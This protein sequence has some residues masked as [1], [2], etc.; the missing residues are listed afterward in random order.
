MTERP[1]LFS[2]AMVRSI[3]QGQKQQ[4]RR[5]VKGDVNG[6]EGVVVRT[7]AQERGHL[8]KHCF[9]SGNESVYQR[10]PYGKA[11]DRLWVR[12]TWR[13]D[14]LPHENP[15]R[16]GTHIGYLYRADPDEKDDPRRPWKPSIHMPRAA[17]RLVLEVT[18]VRV[19]RLLAIT[20]EDSF[21]E[22]IVSLRCPTCH[23]PYGL[24]EWG[25]N[26]LQKTPIEAYWHLWDQINEARGYGRAK[27]PWVWVIEFR[28]AQ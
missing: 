23:R 21:A 24:P 5:V 13:D 1:I 6:Y 9:I 18:G 26:D 14:F 27:N 22:G 25:H 15:D 10:C 12:E 7:V 28:R 16:E 20:V 4:T 11:G 2:G 17:C 8:G 19:E 3:L